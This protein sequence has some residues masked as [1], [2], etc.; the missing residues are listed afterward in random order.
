MGE[1]MS[2]LT[3]N[4]ITM[5]PIAL[6][7]LDHGYQKIWSSNTG[8]T[9]SGEMTGTIIA[10][11]QTIDV[12]FI[13]LRRSQ[14]EIIKQAVNSLTPFVPIAGEMDSGETFAF[15]CY[16]GDLKVNLGCD[17]PKIDGRYDGVSISAI[18]K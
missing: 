4:G 7:G 14:V 15:T 10:I 16:T 5:P 11:K 9:N 2:K 6:G 13:P 18:E 3:I 1:I 17:N 8:R 12:K